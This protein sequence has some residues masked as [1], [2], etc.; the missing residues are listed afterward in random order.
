[1]FAHQK[2]KTRGYNLHLSPSR[3]HHTWFTVKQLRRCVNDNTCAC[4][5]RIL[6]INFA[7]ALFLVVVPCE[8]ECAT[9]PWGPAPSISQEQVRPSDGAPLMSLGETPTRRKHDQE[10]FGL[11]TC[12]NPSLIEF[13]WEDIAL[14]STQERRKD[15]LGQLTTLNGWGRLIL[16]RVT[17]FQPFNY[18]F[19]A[20]PQS[21]HPI[22]QPYAG[23]EGSRNIDQLK[24]FHQKN[25]QQDQMN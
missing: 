18:N 6:L 23:K 9:S 1:M 22:G 7:A 2:K 11:H 10:R 25:H 8:S 12:L 20:T 15:K 5:P 16:A 4:V 19:C 3:L 21:D 14:E 24:K 13:K 17:F